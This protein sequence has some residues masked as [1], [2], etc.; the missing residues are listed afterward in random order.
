MLSVFA[1]LPIISRKF[2]IFSDIF[3]NVAKLLLSLSVLYPAKFTTR[4]VLAHSRACILRAADGSMASLSPV[5][6]L[7]TLI[8]IARLP[9]R[10][11]ASGIGTSISVTADNEPSKGCRANNS[12]PVVSDPAMW[13]RER[14]YDVL[15]PCANVSCHLCKL[16]NFL[17]EPC[18][19]VETSEQIVILDRKTTESLIQNLIQKLWISRGNDMHVIYILSLKNLYTIFQKR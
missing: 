1:I 4:C 13:K 10:E 7:R 16:L 11:I 14:C 12:L 3:Q 17:H 18:K 9:R 15:M 2:Q 19:A 5:H 8:P 6:L